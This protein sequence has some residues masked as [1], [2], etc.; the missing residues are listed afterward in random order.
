LV[1]WLLG[2]I[3]CPGDTAKLRNLKFTVEN[4]KNNRVQT[5]ILELEQ[6]SKNNEK[7]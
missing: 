1:S 5:V 4:V 3:P 7:Q 2:R 6:Q